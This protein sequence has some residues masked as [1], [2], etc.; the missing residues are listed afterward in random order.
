M[1]LRSSGEREVSLET[2]AEVE[3]VA[4]PCLQWVRGVLGRWYSW[5][6]G[7]F[8]P[9]MLLITF[10][11]TYFVKVLVHS[12]VYLFRYQ[13]DTFPGFP[14]FLLLALAALSTQGFMASWEYQCAP[15]IGF[16][17][18]AKVGVLGW[19]RFLLK[20]LG[21]TWALKPSK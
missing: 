12:D 6:C 16:Q 20:G 10:V 9:P 19:H 15:Q 8:L 11:P 13:L 3:K 14:H 4:A 5:I 17:G 1:T 7:G 2:P 21:Q 18:L